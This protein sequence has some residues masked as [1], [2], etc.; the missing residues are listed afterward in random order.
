MSAMLVITLV[1]IAAEAGARTSPGIFFEDAALCSLEKPVVT[2][3]FR[4][5]A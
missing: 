4:N 1:L 2:T 3:T 5:L